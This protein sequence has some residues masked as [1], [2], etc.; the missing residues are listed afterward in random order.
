MNKKILFS[1]VILLL[2]LVA[3]FFV[4]MPKE[5]VK[6]CD[7][8]INL[9]SVV[10]TGNLEGCDCLADEA[11]KTICQKNIS[12]AVIY[13]KAL[14]QTDL[15]LCQEISLSQMK[16]ACLSAIK[17]KIDFLQKSKN[18]TATSTKI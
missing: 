5:E 10:Q 2:I 3:L 4:L 1:I 8:Y 6:K 18:L 13:T 9:D 11:Q 14:K 17:G 16:E 7:P 12:N 15:S